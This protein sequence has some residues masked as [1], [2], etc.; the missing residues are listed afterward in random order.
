MKQGVDF[1]GAVKFSGKEGKGPKRKDSVASEGGDELYDEEEKRK[2]FTKD[3]KKRGEELTKEEGREE[4]SVALDTYMHYARAGGI[5]VAAGILIVQALG[6]GSEI[7]AG[8]WL[9]HWSE[10]SIEAQVRCS[11]SRIMSPLTV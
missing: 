3:E 7:G 8:F 9:A 1:A 10:E 11:E 6:K 5:G 2:T 4:G